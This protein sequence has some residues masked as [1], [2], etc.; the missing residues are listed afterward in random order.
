MSISMSLIKIVV[1]HDITMMNLFLYKMH[2][3]V[4][5]NGD[6]HQRAKERNITAA[7]IGRGEMKAIR[8]G[9]RKVEENTK[10]TI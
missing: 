5:N 1:R 6:T 9:R 7:Q 2:L 4:V 10:K 3:V 8:V